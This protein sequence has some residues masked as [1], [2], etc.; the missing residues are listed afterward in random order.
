MTHHLPWKSLRSG[1]CLLVAGLAAACLLAACG[2]LSAS[3]TCRDYLNASASD[4]SAVLTQLAQQ[5]N[6]PE[7]VSPLGPPGV[8]Y[9]CVETPNKTLGQIAE[10]FTG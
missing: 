4:Q 8:S 3:S 10:G 7:L 2:G 5:Y 9:E 1:A 6:R